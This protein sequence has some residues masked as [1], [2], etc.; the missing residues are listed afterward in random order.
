MKKEDLVFYLVWVSIFILFGV[1]I[2]VAAVGLLPPAESFLLWIV[3]V[4][5]IMM[6]AGMI[7]TRRKPQGD[8]TL[9]FG[10]MLFTIVTL[11]ILALT[12]DVVNAW[13]AVGLAIIFIGIGG[14]GIFIS[15]IKGTIED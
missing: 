2:I 12:T 15:R 13:I 9:L 1:W 3:N 4:G 11:I 6:I 7:K 8:N 10:G 14:L 5:I